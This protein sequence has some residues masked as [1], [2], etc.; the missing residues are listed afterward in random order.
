MRRWLVVWVVGACLGALAS[1]TDDPGDAG[2]T[3][4]TTAAPPAS[5]KPE[6]ALCAEVE[7][8]G[9]LRAED[10]TDA[11]AITALVAA[12]PVERRT[13]AALFYHPYGGD[14]PE[15]VDTSGASAG[16]AGDRLDALYRE[17]CGFEGP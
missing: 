12:L 14:I 3:T 5:A 10:V 13:D 4:S 15:G 1:C 7:R 8:Q 2:P 17:R 9:K 16:Q 11:A 6:T